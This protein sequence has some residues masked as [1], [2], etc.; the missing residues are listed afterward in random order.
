VANG[1]SAYLWHAFCEP[2]AYRLCC[3]FAVTVAESGSEAVSLL[4]AHAPGTFHLVLTVSR[5][6]LCFQAC[7][8]SARAGYSLVLNCMYVVFGQWQEQGGRGCMAQGSF[9]W[10][11]ADDLRPSEY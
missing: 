3:S 5:F 11:D 2:H 6:A 10:Q 4:R 1:G 9:A 8:F 7:C